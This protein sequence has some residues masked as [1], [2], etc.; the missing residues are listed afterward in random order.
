M[1]KIINKEATPSMIEDYVRQSEDQVDLEVTK[2]NTKG[3]FSAF[4]IGAPFAVKDN[5]YS[6]KFWPPGVNIRRFNFNEK[7]TEKDAT[8]NTPTKD[9]SDP[10][11]GTA[12][13]NTTT[14]TIENRVRT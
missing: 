2:L 5:L 11:L 9:P 12:Q 4:R 13:T 3:T 6:E 14:N 1:V 8:S 7:N 10:F